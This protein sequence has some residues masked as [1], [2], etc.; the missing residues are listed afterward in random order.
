MFRLMVNEFLQSCGQQQ[1][2]I[3][4]QPI[5]DFW[6]LLFSLTRAG[7]ILKTIGQNRQEAQLNLQKLLACRQWPHNSE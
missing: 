7:F 1:A 2:Q 3:K 6:R 4:P 5:K